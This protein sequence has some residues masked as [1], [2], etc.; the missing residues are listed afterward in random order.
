[1]SKFGVQVVDR[2]YIDYHESVDRLANMLVDFVR[3][4]PIERTNLRHKTERASVLCDWS[5]MIS[6]Y[7]EA[8]KLAI[9]RRR[10]HFN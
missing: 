8:H 10:K 3:L 2:V 7:N 4:S 6:R 9:T 1:M 5:A